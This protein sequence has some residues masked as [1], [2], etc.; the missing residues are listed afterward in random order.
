MNSNAGS[1][2]RR[3]T[4]VNRTTR[5]DPGAAASSGDTRLRLA[6]FSEA[7]FVID[8][9]ARCITSGNAAAAHAWGTDPIDGLPLDAAMPAW[10]ALLAVVADG[11]DRSKGMQS[12]VFWTHQGPQAWRCMLQSMAVEGRCHVL[13]RLTGGGTSAAPAAVADA[14][15]RDDLSTLAEIA[16]RIRE[17]RLETAVTDRRSAS[18]AARIEAAAS[19]VRIT[20]PDAVRVRPPPLDFLLPANVPAD[21]GT[22]QITDSPAQ[23]DGGRN[24]AIALLAHELR[25]PLSAIVSL[26]EIMR[27]ERLGPMSNA[28][29]KTYAGDIHDSARHTLDLI[30][31]MLIE[32]RPGAQATPPKLDFTGI[33]LNELIRS[34]ASAMEPVAARSGVSVAATLCSD[35]P[36]VV[37]DRRSLRQIVLN[38]MSNALRFTARS[39][40]VTLSTS[41]TDDGGVRM[42]VADTGAGMTPAEIE[43]ALAGRSGA[44]SRMARSATHVPGDTG[45]GFGLPLVRQLVLAHGAALAI[46]S[47]PGQGTRICV[48]FPPHRVVLA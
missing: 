22:D 32:S 23:A 12:L 16:R 41:G 20:R 44:A 30:A 8:P 47:Q 10:R 2:A 11:P 29:Y 34:C 24:Q 38:L 33:D 35:R 40:T 17:G 9:V 43:A 4:I 7:A 1:G 6:Q 45:S 28:R 5:I 36:H 18:P 25:T 27:D 3:L 31:T 46:D 21:A 26:S 48:M 19:S 15:S 42:I 37:A 14:K 39:G 13:V